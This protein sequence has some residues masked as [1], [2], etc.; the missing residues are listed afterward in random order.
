MDGRHDLRSFS[1]VFQSYQ[2]DGK[3]KMSSGILLRLK[4]S[5]SRN[6]TGP[7]R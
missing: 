1:T 4:I 2:G 3:V 7:A 6:L 5:A